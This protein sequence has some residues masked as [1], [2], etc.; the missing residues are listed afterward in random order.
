MSQDS[1]ANLALQDYE[2]YEEQRME[3]NA[4]RVASQLG[5]LEIFA[6]GIR[7]PELGIRNT[8]V[9]IRNPTNNSNPESKFH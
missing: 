7:N 1:I 8:G 6:C 5:I 3:K 4:R 9:G 2:E